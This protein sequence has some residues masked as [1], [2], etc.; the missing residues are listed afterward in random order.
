PGAAG[1]A[2]GALVAALGAGQ[3]I[4]AALRSWADGLGGGDAALVEAAILVQF[5]TGGNLADKFLLLRQILEQRGDL[6]A[7]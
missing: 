1:Q 5:E 7:A 2:T 3:P 6:A 4:H